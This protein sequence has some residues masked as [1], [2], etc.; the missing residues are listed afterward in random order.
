[1]KLKYLL[2]QVTSGHVATNIIPGGF[3]SMMRR[4]QFKSSG[5]LITFK[6]EKKKDKEK[7]KG[8]IYFAKAKKPGYIYENKEYKNLEKNKVSLTDEERKIVFAKD[9]VWHYATSIDPNTGKKVKKVSAVWK[10]KNPKTGEITYITSTHRAW[11]KASTLK[12]AINRY[13]V[14]IKGTA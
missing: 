13:H 6:K 7:T 14:F 11:N 2:D 9:A 5:Y 1:M 3:I 4:P 10:S 12:G 8:V